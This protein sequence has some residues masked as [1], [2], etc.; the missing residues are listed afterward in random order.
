MPVR[1]FAATILRDA[2]SETSAHMIPLSDE[3]PTLRTP[4]MTWLI[5]GA[6]FAVWLVVQGGGLPGSD[7]QLATSICNLGMVPG[8]L[9]ASRAGR[10]RGSARRRD[11]RAS[12]TTTR[13]TS[14]RR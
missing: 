7:L 3:N 2:R 11:S 6:M 9:T 10:L 13:S 14:S 8:E 1:P 12:S 5:L 4:M